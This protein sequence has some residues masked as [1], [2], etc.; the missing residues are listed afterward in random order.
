[1]ATITL[2]P[3]GT[4]GKDARIISNQA[5]VNYGI[6]TVLAVGNSGANLQRSLIQFDFSSIPASAI[7][8]SAVLSIYAL[9]DFASSASTYSVYRLKRV[10][11]EGTRNGV[12][13]SP[14]TGVTWNRYDTTNNWQTAG[15]NGSDDRETTAIG[16]RAF[17]A[18]ETL[19]Q[20]KDFTLDNTAVQQMIAG[21]FTNNG[22]LLR[23]DEAAADL[24]TFA[25]SDNATSANRPKLVITYTVPAGGLMYYG[26]FSGGLL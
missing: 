16:T 8:S 12:V 2:Q 13:D 21:T 6:E 7:V 26:Q 3:D 25:S 20:F 19:N 14:A 24:Y 18:T 5:T 4:A 9:A 15:A 11:V 22:F 1:M 10:W 17:T 23:S